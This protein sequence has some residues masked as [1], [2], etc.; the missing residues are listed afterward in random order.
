MSSGLHHQQKDLSFVQ[1][2]PDDVQDASG[3]KWAPGLRGSLPRQEAATSAGSLQVP[4]MAAAVGACFASRSITRKKRAVKIQR[5]DGGVPTAAATT[6]HPAAFSGHA[7]WTGLTP[8]KEY[9]LQTMTANVAK[10]TTTIR[11]LDWDRDRFDIEFALERGTTYNSYIIKGAEKTALVD[12]SHEKFSSL[13]FDALLK[14][15]DLAKLDYLIVSHTEPDHSG[16]IGDVLARA[17]E[18]GNEDL[19]V[20]GSKICIGFLQNLMHE[21][22]KHKAIAQGDKIDLGGGHE[23]EFT[24][25]PNLHWPDTIFTFDHGTGLL[26][27]CDAFGMHYCSE[28]LYDTEGMKELL[29]HYALYYD[30]LMK[31][32]A[33]S[34]LTALKKTSAWDFHTVATGHGPMLQHHTAEWVDKYQSW[35]DGAMKNNGPSVALFWI[36]SFGE[37]ER[38]AQLFAHGLGNTGVSVEMQDLNAVDAFELTECLA[39]ND[40]LAVM[41]P[42]QGKNDA[43]SALATI[44]ANAK[45]KEH[46]FMVLD[47]FSPEQEPLDMIERSFRGSEIPQALPTL[48][49]QGEMGP[50]IMQGYEEA[51][52]SLGKQMSKK[53]KLSKAA[54]LDAEMERA[55]GRL[56]SS[57]YVVTAHKQGIDHAMVASFCTPASSAPMGVSLSIAKDRAM[58]PLLRAGDDFVVNFLE[59]GRSL[60]LMKHFLKSFAPGANRLEGVDNFK[61]NN[62]AA[63]LRDAC[64]YLECRIVSRM[65]CSDHW[66]AYAEVTG[67]N[68]ARSEAEVAAHHRK[69]G[70]TY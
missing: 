11:S 50:A 44:V 52:M 32:N 17:K 26:Y 31:P 10:D 24:I 39:R 49:M 8:G 30:C 43:Q 12:T 59:E 2:L 47:S 16:L 1:P 41:A 63:V 46:K 4:A 56:S 35:S 33:R 66:L 64:A 38:L 65:D 28:E 69:V 18:A 5:Q 34:V 51:G 60:P 54:K 58:E 42:P 13:W 9:Q 61:G 67:G 62:G 70:S 15:V 57:L 21:P 40:V 7:T 55:L 68:V 37:S 27:T 29:P 25:A 23:L 20:V 48:T 3:R 22:F 45:V 53:I 36:S 19:T 6:G 14:E